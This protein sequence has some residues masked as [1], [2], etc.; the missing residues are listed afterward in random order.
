MNYKEIVKKQQDY[1]NCMHSLRSNIIE[2]LKENI[3]EEDFLD[4][5]DSSF[6][7]LDEDDT[8]AKTSL[9][10]GVG[11]TPNEG[12]YCRVQDGYELCPEDMDPIDLFNVAFCVNHILEENKKNFPHVKVGNYVHWNDPAINDF[13]PEDREEQLNL[14]WEIQQIDGTLIED[15]TVVHI[16]REDGGEAE[17]YAHE[18]RPLKIGA[19]DLL[20]N[21]RKAWDKLKEVWAECKA[22][23]IDFVSSEGLVMA[24]NGKNVAKYEWK[25]D[26]YPEDDEECRYLDDLDVSDCVKID[27][28]SFS[29]EGFEDVAVLK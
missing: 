12:I 28:Y 3:K 24:I 9:C 29:A 20:P 17:V 25:D 21:Q 22:T 1:R 16:T 8:R 15:S 26:F 6:H 14:V 13:E 11:N 23:G 19:L 27:D 4:F 10:V 18:L 2:W 5:G 7:I